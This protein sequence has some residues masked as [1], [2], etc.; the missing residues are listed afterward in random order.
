MRLKL[1]DLQSLEKAKKTVV[2]N[3]SDYI[4]FLDSRTGRSMRPCCGLA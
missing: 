3:D 2:P 4:T 1:S